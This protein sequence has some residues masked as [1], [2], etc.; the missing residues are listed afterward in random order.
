MT[1]EARANGRRCLLRFKF[2]N[3]NGKKMETRKRV[4]ALSTPTFMDSVSFERE[5]YCVSEGWAKSME[6][7]FV[8]TLC[9]DSGS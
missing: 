5:A 3:V 7:V 8:C 2:T 4:D 9:A 1:Q 6:A